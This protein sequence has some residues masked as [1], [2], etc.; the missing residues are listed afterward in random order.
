[1]DSSIDNKPIEARLQDAAKGLAEA[2]RAHE[3][4]IADEGRK[5]D[6]LLKARQRYDALYAELLQSHRALQEES[7]VYLQRATETR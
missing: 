4:S 5:L 6:Q 3:Y 1:M 7:S 2:Q